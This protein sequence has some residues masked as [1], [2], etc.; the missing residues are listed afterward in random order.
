VAV[1]AA[2][3]VGDVAGV[4][5]GLK[6]PNDLVAQAADG[7][8]RKVAG[9]LAESILAGGRLEAAVVGTGMNVNWPEDGTVDLPPGAGA[10]NQLAGSPVD[11][12]ELLVAWLGRLDH[13]WETITSGRADEL[14]AAY[15]SR[16]STL[17]QR[18]A[19]ETPDGTLQGQAVDITEEGH[20]VIDTATG[21]RT[22]AVGDVVHLRPT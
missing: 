3:A 1:S 17:G 22:F 10:V 7:D 12:A 15:R 11:R 5:L 8:V 18:V 21:R 9:V 4:E 6:W 16:L 2:E 13:W 14:L 20:L 19:I